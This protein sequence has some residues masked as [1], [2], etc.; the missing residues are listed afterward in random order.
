MGM[1][2]LWASWSGAIYTKRVKKDKTD[3]FTCVVLA[4]CCC[5]SFPR[6]RAAALWP[7]ANVRAVTTEKHIAAKTDCRHKKGL[8]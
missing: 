6:I 2:K 1:A 5:R 4:L 7:E 3:P 8:E